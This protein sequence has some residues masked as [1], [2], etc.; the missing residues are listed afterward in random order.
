MINDFIRSHIKIYL[1]ITLYS[2]MLTYKHL[3]IIQRETYQVGLCVKVSKIY[4]DSEKLKEGVEGKIQW[5]Y[6][7][8]YFQTKQNAAP[9][10]GWKEVKEKLT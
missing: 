3:F 7:R 2:F 6:I 4:K 5:K 10:I 9:G 1:V 8:T